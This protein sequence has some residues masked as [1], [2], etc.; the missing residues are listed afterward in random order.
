MGQYGLIGSLIRK[1]M[2]EGDTDKSSNNIW[3]DA[4]NQRGWG[5]LGNAYSAAP[6][7]SVGTPYLNYGTEQQPKTLLD[8]LAQMMPG[9]TQQSTSTPFQFSLWGGR[10]PGGY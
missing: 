7:F 10:R 9:L 1:K 6:E 8:M 4:V 5:N 2:F 3:A